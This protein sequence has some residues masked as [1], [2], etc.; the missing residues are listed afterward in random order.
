MVPHSTIRRVLLPLLAAPSIPQALLS[1]L[2]PEI[3]SHYR[4]S[5]FFR[6]LQNTLPQDSLQDSLFTDRVLIISCEGKRWVYP[7]FI[8]NTEAS[9]IMFKEDLAAGEDGITLNYEAGNTP[10]TPRLGCVLGDL[11]YSNCRFSNILRAQ[12]TNR[13]AISILKMGKNA[14]PSAATGAIFPC[15]SGPET[16]TSSTLTDRPRIA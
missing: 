5:H 7:Y 12:N 4:G 3:A 1:R 10:I 9:A 2:C 8:R 15:C 13:F 14:S 11:A 6:P 16:S